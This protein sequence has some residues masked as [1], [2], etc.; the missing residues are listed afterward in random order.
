MEREPGDVFEQIDQL[1]K[2]LNAQDHVVTIVDDNILHY[3]YQ[4]DLMIS[5]I[6]TACYSGFIL[7]GRSYLQIL[8]PVI[9]F[10]PTIFPQIP[11]RGMLAIY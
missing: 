3:M 4:A 2:D 8:L 1:I 10:H 5:D 9:I 7:I 6:S 11:M